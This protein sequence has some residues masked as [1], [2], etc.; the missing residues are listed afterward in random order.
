MHLHMNEIHRN[1]NDHQITEIHTQKTDQDE[2]IKFTYD[3][4]IYTHIFE[5]IF[6]FLMIQKYVHIASMTP[7][8]PLVVN[9]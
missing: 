3:H 5:H 2:R 6:F 1:I 8:N 7:H 9:V 4:R